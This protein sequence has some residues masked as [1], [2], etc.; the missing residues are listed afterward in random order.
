MPLLPLLPLSGGETA[1]CEAPC[2]DG[3]VYPRPRDV[4]IFYVL[5]GV[6]KIASASITLALFPI[7]LV[8]VGGGWWGG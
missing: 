3:R 7:G 2:L 4:A 8:A 1:A 5:L 6:P